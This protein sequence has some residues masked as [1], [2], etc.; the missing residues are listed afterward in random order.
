[1]DASSGFR[2]RGWLVDGKFDGE[3][4]VFDAHRER[5]KADRR[6]GM[7]EN[8]STVE[9]EG[10]GMKRA[11]DAGTGDHAVGKRAVSVRAAV[12][13]SEERVSQIEDG[14]ATTGDFDGLSLAHGNAV[15]TG[16]A[17]PMRRR[18]HS[19]LSRG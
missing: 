10:P 18:A 7:V 16:Q 5:D 12:I 17:N 11:S 8:L 13:D 6:F 19:E 15:A 9:V 1:M 14:D 3:E 2:N 4:T